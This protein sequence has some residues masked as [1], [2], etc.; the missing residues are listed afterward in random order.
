M[1]KDKQRHA[2]SHKDPQRST[3]ADEV[4]RRRIAW[5]RELKRLSREVYSNITHPYINVNNSLCDV[6]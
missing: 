4:M 3:K 2:K 6:I 1:N 5:A